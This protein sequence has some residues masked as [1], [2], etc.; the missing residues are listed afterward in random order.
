[1]I[2]LQ[3]IKKSKAAQI[4]IL[5]VFFHIFWLLFYI[6]ANANFLKPFNLNYYLKTSAINSIGFAA[7]CLSVYWLFPFFISTKKFVAFVIFSFSIIILFGYLQYYTQDWNPKMFSKTKPLV[8]DGKKV[9]SFTA[10]QVKQSVGSQ[11]R[12]MLNIM[13][14]LLLGTGFAYM[15]DWFVKDHYTQ[16][17]EKEKF[18]AELAMLRYQFNPHFLFNIINNIYYLAIIKS[19]KTADAILKV[20]ELLRYVLNEKEEWVPLEI[21][22]EYLKEFVNLQ[23]FRFPDQ[24]VELHSNINQDT[25]KYKIAP[26]LLITFAENAF[27]HGSPGTKEEPVTFWLNFDKN[28]LEYRV[29]NKINENDQKDATTG[30]G[31][32][33]LER[34]LY[35]LYP[36]K[37]QIKITEENNFFDAYLKIDL[38]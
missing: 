23:Q 5:F 37:Y 18:K 21:E 28:Q 29:L 2:F 33:N 10:I 25:K 16:T 7:F 4:L 34:R 24:V 27:K 3:R 36:N 11:V 14:Y 32:H 20:S 17:L 35:L 26:L 31:L 12:A 13:V 1:M 15:K 19:D 38:T 30:I 6:L 9:I 22:L 8:A